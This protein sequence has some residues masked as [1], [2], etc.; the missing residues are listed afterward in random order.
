[1]QRNGKEVVDR[2]DVGPGLAAHSGPFTA[3]VD[4]RFRVAGNAAPG[5]G[6]VLTLSAGF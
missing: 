5:S 3:Q 1:M 6:P 4:Y 2:L